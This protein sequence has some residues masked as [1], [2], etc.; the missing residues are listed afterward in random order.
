MSYEEMVKLYRYSVIRSHRDTDG[1]WERVEGSGLTLAEAK[2]KAAELGAAEHKAYPTKT[3]WTIDSFIPQL[4]DSEA[5][6]AE[7]T[8]RRLRRCEGL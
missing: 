4:E 1:T 7:L 6:H 2:A 5:I 3:S 8:A